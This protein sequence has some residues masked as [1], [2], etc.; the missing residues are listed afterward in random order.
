[1][2]IPAYF[3]HII[4]N[5]KNIVKKMI[6]F[7]FHNLFM[8]CNSIVYDSYY[9]L[10]K[11][12][13]V[14]DLDIEV[15]I[16]NSVIKKIDEY[17]RIVKPSNTIF[18]A[19][20]GVAPFAKMEQQR[21]RR[22][23]SWF[24]SN[25]T[26]KS[27]IWSTVNITPGTKFMNSLMEAVEK[28]LLEKKNK[29]N[30]KNVIFS[31]SN[32]CGEG[33]HK[34]FEYMRNNKNNEENTIV[35]GLDADLIM[36][37]IFHLEYFKN[38]YIFREAPE[39]LK[40]YIP[41]KMERDDE[42][43]IL[44]IKTL[45]NAILS[46]LN[47]RCFDN[48][49]IYD[50]VFLCFFLGNDFLPHFPCMNIRT[51]GINVLLDVY[52]KYI[53]NN[54][55]SFLISKETRQIEWDNVYILIK[56]IASFEHQL[57]LDEYSVRDKFDNKKRDNNN[58]DLEALIQDAP[59]LYR[60]DEKYIHPQEKFWQERYYKALFGIDRTNDNIKEIC[61]NYLEGLEW[62][63]KYYTGNCPDWRWKYNYSYPPL[64]SDLFSNIHKGKYDLIKNTN[65]P[66][67]PIVQLSY[68]LSLKQL[69]ILPISMK[70]KIIKNYI[71]FYPEKIEFKWAFCR[72]FWESHVILPEIPLKIMDEWER[73]K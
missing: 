24:V 10:C 57:L 30:C 62:V 17:I 63:Y 23:K 18:I 40:N 25:V 65:K 61:N 33:E 31:S 44:D 34:L 16:I 5:Y 13:N 56:N 70:E 55:R 46:E 12:N 71:D 29:Y 15:E 32:E 9:K 73:I 14:K 60:I 11:T 36:L 2:G 51:H 4:R 72:Y 26:N 45:S 66:F 28:F 53:A 67:S 3:S 42:P 19:F 50:Y 69:D 43:F 27:E 39:F 58:I 7:T 20:D 59:I 48:H 22:Y 47:C 35:Y 64:F 41:I 21:S 68:V 52:K 1:M 6:G 37:S 54:T 8:D 49:R 38:I